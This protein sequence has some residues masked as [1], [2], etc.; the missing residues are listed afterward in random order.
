VLVLTLQLVILSCPKYVCLRKA[1]SYLLAEVIVVPLES[2][3]L[4]NQTPAYTSSA[5]RRGTLELNLRKLEEFS[6]VLSKYLRSLFCGQR[7]VNLAISFIR[8]LK[9]AQPEGVI[10]FTNGGRY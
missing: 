1:C 6:S 8:H 10:A 7:N 3:Y 2:L 4:Y 5:T 9:V